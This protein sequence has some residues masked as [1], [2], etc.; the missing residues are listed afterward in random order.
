MRHSGIDFFSLV[1][2]STSGINAGDVVIDNH[3]TLLWVF[4][5]IEE[6]ILSF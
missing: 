3:K 6:K 1:G 5:L 2:K 4:D